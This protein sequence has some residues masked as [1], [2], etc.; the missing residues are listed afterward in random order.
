[1]RRFLPLIFVAILSLFVFALPTFAADSLE[2][3]LC[4]Y[5]ESPNYRSQHAVA[6]H[7]GQLV[8]VDPTTQQTLSTLDTDFLHFHPI[9]I[10]WTHNCRYVIT[11]NVWM[12]NDLYDYAIRFSSMY[13]TFTGE[14]IG[15]W[16]R[17]EFFALRYSPTNQHFIMKRVDGTYLMSETFNAPVLMFKHNSRGRSMR[18]YEWDLAR[19]ELLVVFFDNSGYVVRYDLNTGAELAAISNPP[20]CTPPVN[21][22]KAEDERYL[23]VFTD[24]GR[25]GSP[26]CVTVYNRD[27]N[28]S[29]Q[30]NAGEMTGGTRDAIALSPDG[31]YLLLGSRALRVWDLANLPADFA[32]REP[33]YRH[34]GPLYVIDSLRFVAPTVVETHSDDG[35]QQWDILTGQQVN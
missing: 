29:W 7:D 15:R 19:G 35:V 17:D 28:Q 27:T 25:G 22:K 24:A 30:I 5:T 1:M 32:A 6:V 21:F 9:D 4:P 12:P 16:R 13:D 2:P 20:G 31:R 14:R 11:L 33:I 8:L 10:F 26:A 34:E 18:Q 3:K 23:L